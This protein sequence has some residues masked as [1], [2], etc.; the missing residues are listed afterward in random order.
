MTLIEVIIA[1]ALFSMVAV[2]TVSSTTVG[3]KLKKKIQGSG[4]YYHNARTAIRQ[5]DRDI[6][7]AYHSYQDTKQG[8]L[9]KQQQI[10][11]HVYDNVWPPLSSFFKGEKDKLLFSSSSHQRLYKNTNEEDISEVS[12][13][14]EA[15]DK[16]P[17]LFNLFK[18]QTTFIDEDIEHGGSTYL[19]ANGIESMTFRYLRAEAKDGDEYWVDKWDSTAGDYVSKFPLAVEVTLVFVPIQQPEK[20][21]TVV[22][23][24]KILN[25]NNVGGTGFS[26]S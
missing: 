1:L 3:L 26:A 12:Y 8:E 21:L 15:D 20:K 11:T 22:Q 14:L 16:N 24:I 13:Y 19:I 6:G 10:A 7:L 18:R 17:G 9:N 2:F 4:D 5:L 23:K 25:P